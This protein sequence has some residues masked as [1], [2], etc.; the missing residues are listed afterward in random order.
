MHILPFI[1][2]AMKMNEEEERVTLENFMDSSILECLL[3]ETE[4]KKIIQL[5]GNHTLSCAN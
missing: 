3:N 4:I 5:I 2:V 1:H